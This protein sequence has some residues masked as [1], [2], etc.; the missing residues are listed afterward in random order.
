MPFVGI[1][2]G[3]GR[4][5]FASGGEVTPF[6]FTIDTTNTSVGSTNADQFRLPLSSS[7][8]PITPDFT[9]YWGDGSSDY[10]NSFTSPIHT[11][12]SAGVYTI[13]IVGAISG[14]KFNNSNDRL[15]MLNV[16]SWGA[17]TNLGSLSTSGNSSDFFGCSNLTSNATDSPI[18]G[19]SQSSLFRACSSLNGGLANWDVSQVTSL[20]GTFRNASSFN[21]NIGSWDVGNVT[22][23]QNMFLS[24]SA[25]NNGGSD[26]IKNW[27]TSSA[28]NMAQMFLLTNAFN[29]PI[30]DWD[31][32]NV[33]TFGNI[34]NNSSY[35]YLDDIYQKWSLQSVQP[36]LT[37]GFGTAKYT[38]AGA[39]GRSVLTSPPN[40]WTITD[41]GLI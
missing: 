39:S 2:V 13:T 9:I 38:I 27:N 4:Q 24:Q 35:S 6:Q 10:V 37:I 40:N 22:I 34:I 1:G 20:N 21:Q 14:I 16:N 32:S 23:F 8:A 30:G 17:L 19:G 15:K 36:N 7:N 25:F 3:I 31:I 33:T 28:T 18:L 12:S 26:S 11:Y 41:G 29:Q 5:R